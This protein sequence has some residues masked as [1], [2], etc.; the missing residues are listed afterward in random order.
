MVVDDSNASGAAAGFY[1]SVTVS[2]G[3]APPPDERIIDMPVQT[4]QHINTR[5]VDVERTRDFYVSI[6]GLRVGP[7]PPFASKGYWLYLGEDPVV[8]LV[9]RGDGD[10]PPPGS[11]NVDH[12]AFHTTD[13]D[14]MRSALATAG[15]PFRETVVPR[16]G[17]VQI[18]IHDPDG[19][20]LELNF[21][22]LDG[23]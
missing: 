15:V 21:A 13:L 22:A 17:T 6:L 23:S 12:V 11:G 1:G 19:V 4:F 14:G 3:R 9:Q 18:F 16:D 5:S 8:H 7:R 10:T 2:K 20:R